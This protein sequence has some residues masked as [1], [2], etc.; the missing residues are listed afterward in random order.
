VALATCST[1]A[2]HPG[3]HANDVINMSGAPSGRMGGS[4][5]GRY[6]CMYSSVTV[7]VR[8]SERPSGSPLS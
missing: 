2:C 6:R 7:T 5:S 4:V 3:C 1:Y 8:F